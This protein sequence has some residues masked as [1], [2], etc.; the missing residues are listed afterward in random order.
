VILD[1]TEKMD[2]RVANPDDPYYVSNYYVYHYAK[3]E[4]TEDAPEKVDA[5]KTEDAAEKVEKRVQAS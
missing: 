4:D 1:P 3:K 2:K 5:A